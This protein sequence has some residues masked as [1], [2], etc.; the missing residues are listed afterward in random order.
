MCVGEWMKE[1]WNK[2]VIAT[3][4]DPDLPEHAAILQRIHSSWEL[5]DQAG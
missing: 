1:G 3:L 5:I 4:G 2:D